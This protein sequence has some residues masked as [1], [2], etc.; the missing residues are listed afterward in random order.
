MYDRNLSL[1]SAPKAHDPQ[2]PAVS[3][4]GFGPFFEHYIVQ[5]FN[6][7]Y[8]KK[9]ENRQCSSSY[10]SQFPKGQASKYAWAF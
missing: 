7:F 9:N 3:L 1:E 2:G 10:L 8:F 4:D 6:Y 5:S